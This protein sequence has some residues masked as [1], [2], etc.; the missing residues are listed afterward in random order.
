MSGGGDIPV[1]TPILAHDLVFITNAH[2]DGA[3]IYAIRPTAEGDISLADGATT[4]EFVAW[5][6]AR[7]GAYMQTPLAYGDNLYLCRDNGILTIFEA[8]TG[9]KLSQAR[10]GDGS[11]GFTASPVA[12]DGK[13]YFTSEMGDIV[14]VKAGVPEAE[15]IATNEMGEICMATPAISEGILLFRTQGHL[16]AIAQAETKRAAN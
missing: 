8:R 9:K 6:R 11:T 16:I 14:V 1:P 15:V 7:Q 13:I 3:P 2:G 10:L 5:S 12:A 4:N